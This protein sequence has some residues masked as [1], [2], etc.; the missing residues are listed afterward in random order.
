MGAG[1]SLHRK[2]DEGIDPLKDDGVIVPTDFP[3]TTRLGNA[4]AKAAAPPPPASAG[5]AAE[6]AAPAKAAAPAAAALSSCDVTPMGGSADEQA[7]SVRAE[8]KPY[9]LWTEQEV[10]ACGDVRK[11]RQALVS[12][13][14][15]FMKAHRECFNLRNEVTRLTEQQ[16]QRASA[17]TTAKAASSVVSDFPAATAQGA[18]AADDAG[19]SRL[20]SSCNKAPTPT[21]TPV[22]KAAAAPPASRSSEEW[23][24]STDTTSP[25]APHASATTQLLIHHA[26]EGNAEGAAALLDAGGVSVD[27]LDHNKRSALHHA[28]EGGSL[29]VVQVL[30]DNGANVNQTDAWGETPLRVALQHVNNDVANFLMEKHAVMGDGAVQHMMKLNSRENEVFCKKVLAAC[31]IPNPT[32]DAPQGAF[33]SILGFCYFLYHEYGVDVTINDGILREVIHLAETA[34]HNACKVFLAQQSRTPETLNGVELTDQAKALV[35]KVVM[36]LGDT[37][38]NTKVLNIN[39]LRENKLRSKESMIY[40]ISTGNAVIGKWDVFCR[41]LGELCEEVLGGPNDGANAAYIPELSGVNPEL[42]A[43]SVCTVD[44]QQFTYGS[45]CT[46][47]LQSCAKPLLYAATLDLVGKDA[48]TARVGNEQSGKHYNDLTAVVQNKSTKPYNGLTNA[49]SMVTA[50]MYYPEL[51]LEPRFDRFLSKVRDMAGGQHVK[52]N[53]EVFDSEKK[54]AYRNYA[55]ANLLTAEGSFPDHVQKYV[56]QQHTRDTHNLSLPLAS[57]LPT[58]T[59]TRTSATSWTSTSRCAPCR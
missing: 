55:I 1:G 29:D 13:Q 23:D 44:G 17:A 50:S 24:A 14:Y 35:K 43:V 51:E 48:L 38:M 54:S 26:L 45:N 57:R 41:L 5:G 12:A 42:F 56:T 15:E 3:K 20:A 34:K 18:A 16:H 58:H 4:P 7:L 59:A 21:P 52:L 32:T 33:V 22:A 49:G 10:H 36:R 30:W 11:L 2:G 19:S 31:H 9:E 8:D 37:L 53:Q 47:T 39:S 27:G 28:C 6:A 40:R 25:P 46:F